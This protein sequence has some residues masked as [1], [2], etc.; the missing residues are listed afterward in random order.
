MK[1]FYCASLNNYQIGSF[2]RQCLASCVVFEKRLD[3]FHTFV[4]WDPRKADSEVAERNAYKKLSNYIFSSLKTFK[5]EENE[6]PNFEE[7][8]DSYIR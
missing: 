8:Y 2:A 1:E 3:K 6:E 5:I 4:V 7:W